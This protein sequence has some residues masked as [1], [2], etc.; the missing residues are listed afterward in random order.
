MNRLKEKY[1]KEVVPAMKEKFGYR[2]NLAVPKIDK[3]VLNVGISV[4]KGDKNFFE[5]VARTLSR[6]TGQKA[7]FIKAKRSIASFKIREGNIIGA[8]VTLRNEKMYSFLIKLIDLTL[9][10]VRDFR[11]LNI[12]SVDKGGNL[13]I[14]F[15][16]HIIFPEISAD[17][18][19]NVHGLEAVIAT[20]AKTMQEGQELLKLIGFPFQK[21][22]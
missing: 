9:P 18:V 4:S 22:N 16:E 13:T 2:N 5:L 11:G 3:V 6:I 15:K 17:E 20:T 21:I 1:I 12:K 19:E 7:V 14:G 8:K 10:N